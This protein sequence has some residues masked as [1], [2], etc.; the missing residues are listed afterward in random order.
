MSPAF[1]VATSASFAS[2]T[3]SS[4]SVLS[5][6]SY[7]IYSSLD[8][9]KHFVRAALM[10]AAVFVVSVTK[11]MSLAHNPITFDAFSDA[12]SFNLE[13]TSA[14]EASSLPVSSL[15]CFLRSA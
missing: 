1:F 7:L 11:S 10:T 14:S 13:R 8:K 2:I 5:T 15:Y 3:V 12:I 4:S 6:L 9:S